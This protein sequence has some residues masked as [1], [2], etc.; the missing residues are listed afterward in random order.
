MWAQTLAQDA[1]G[2]FGFSNLG[3]LQHMSGHSPE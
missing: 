2:G 3:G 1:Q